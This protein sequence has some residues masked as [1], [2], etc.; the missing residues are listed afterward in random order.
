MQ[1][2]S[3]H[4]LHK[5]FYEPR[6]HIS[7]SPKGL[8]ATSTT[9][10]E[11]IL[12]LLFSGRVS[13]IRIPDFYPRHLCRRM[14]RWLYNHPD[15][16]VYGQNAVN[17]HT[18]EIEYHD[19]FVDRIGEPRNRLIGKPTDAPEW[20]T[21]FRKAEQIQTEIAELTQQQHPVQQLIDL[22]DRI[23]LCG[24]RKEQ[25][26]GRV[27]A[28]GI[29]RVTRP[30]QAKAVYPLEHPHVDGPWPCE[31][32]FGVNV[33]FSMPPRGGELEAFCG[34][35]LSAEEMQKIPFNHDFRQ[36]HR[37][38]ELV[39]PHIGDLIIVNTRRPHAVTPFSHGPR[40]SMSCFM[41]FDA[42]RPLR[43]YS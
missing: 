24:A 38:S 26:R 13:A 7:R 10:S 35:T 23:W 5:V 14:E 1:Y 9:L 20:Q 39:R 21:Y 29:G 32:H 4:Q 30:A 36:T 42:D 17:P 2:G 11:E 40:V 16:T 22:L 3:L 37:V 27:A 18:G 28:A 19:Y 31:Q 33:Y 43:F 41:M 25:I 8:I 6:P 12:D 15:R 34:P